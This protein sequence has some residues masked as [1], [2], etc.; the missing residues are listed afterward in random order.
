[1]SILKF[2]FLTDLYK[3]ESICTYSETSCRAAD[4]N[5]NINCN[6]IIMVLVVSF[7]TSTSRILRYNNV[8]LCKTTIR[9]TRIMKKS[10]K[11]LLEIFRSFPKVYLIPTHQN[12]HY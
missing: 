2:T 7:T 1:M 3:S 10:F 4:Y 8:F 11:D 12:V 6:K 9:D 5:M